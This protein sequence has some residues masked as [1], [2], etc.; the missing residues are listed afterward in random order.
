[1][2]TI[3]VHGL[4]DVPYLKND[5]AILFWIIFGLTI[6]IY[7][8]RRGAGVVERAALEKQ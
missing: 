6:S 4:V 5:L 7:N 1:M 8:T 3:L 2:I